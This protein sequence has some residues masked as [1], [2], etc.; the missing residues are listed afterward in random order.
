MQKRR[1]GKELDKKYDSKR[2]REKGKKK[3]KI[4]K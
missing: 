4:E 1:R 3:R 2:K